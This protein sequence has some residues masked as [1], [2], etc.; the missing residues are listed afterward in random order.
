M[1][2]RVLLWSLSISAFPA[3]V[4]SLYMKPNATSVF[5][6][7][8]TFEVLVEELLNDYEEFYLFDHP[9]NRSYIKTVGVRNSEP[10]GLT[11]E[12]DPDEEAEI[13]C[14]Y[15]DPYEPDYLDSITYHHYDLEVTGDRDR[16]SYERRYRLM[17]YPNDLRN[18]TFANALES[19]SNYF[20]G[21]TFHYC[22][23]TWPPKDPFRDG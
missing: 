8:T 16:S 19:I 5:F 4:S 15:K 23:V 7:K 17:K 22:D 12:L 21:V 20:P 14:E 6:V 1:R 11:P 13:D 2:C 18:T 9:L 3:A 10:M